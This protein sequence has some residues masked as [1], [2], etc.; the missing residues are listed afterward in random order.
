MCGFA[1]QTSAIALSGSRGS[2]DSTC[3][4]CSKLNETTFLVVED[5]KWGEQPFIYVKVYESSLVLI[6]TGCGGAAKDES[7][8]LT[9]LRQF[10]ETYAVADNDDQPLN[11]GARAAYVVLCTHCH[12]DHIGTA[13]LALHYLG[14]RSLT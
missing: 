8:K 5:D 12:F 4:S 10:L 14:L 1:G 9:S 11:P 2:D 13:C 7:V 3:F 6:D